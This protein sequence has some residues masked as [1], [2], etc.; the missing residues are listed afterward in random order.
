MKRTILVP[1]GNLLQ[2]A[3]SGGLAVHAFQVT[4]KADVLRLIA[5]ASALQR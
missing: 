5:A 1:V 2:A 4:D 3:G